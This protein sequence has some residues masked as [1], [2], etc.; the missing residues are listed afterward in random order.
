M[1]LTSYTPSD[2]FEQSLRSALLE[3]VGMIAKLL[4]KQST[5]GEAIHKPSKKVMHKSMCMTLFCTGNYSSEEVSSR[6]L[7]LERTTSRWGT[8][9]LAAIRL[10][11]S[12]WLNAWETAS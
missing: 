4:E 10:G 11:F 8:M 2:E 7:Q 9:I 5:D 12:V 1:K 6:V 3:R